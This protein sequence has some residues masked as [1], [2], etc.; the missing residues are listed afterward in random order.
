MGSVA[1][2]EIRDAFLK[3]LESERNLSAHTIRAYLG[4]LDSFFEHL[5]KLDVTD[6]SKLELSHIR[7]WLANQQVKGG[8]R[9]TLSRRAVSIRLFTKWATK[10]GYLAKD[11]GATLATPKGARTLPD[12][13]NV[14]DAGLAMDALATRVA[15]ED[16]PLSKRDCAMVE[17]LYASGARVSE[18]CGLDLQ[19]IDYERNTIRVIGKGNKERT[20]PLGNPAMRAL[21]AWL[22]EGRP[23]LAGDKSDR[24][25]FLGARGKRIDQ[26]TVRTVVYQALEALEGAVKLGPHALRHSAATHLLEGGADLRTVQEILGHASLATTQIYTHVST[27]RLQKAFKQAHPRA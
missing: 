14:A 2:S 10:K 20:I 16:G 13:L 11:V 6:F 15:E 24:A 22:K 3:Y 5:E 26:R 17:V 23:S 27:E 19:D 1:L 9:T 4:D 25:V 12:V 7:S 8:A 18:L 21:D